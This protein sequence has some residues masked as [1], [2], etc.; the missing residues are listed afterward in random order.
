MEKRDEIY[1][2]IE[3]ISYEIMRPCYGLKMKFNVKLSYPDQKSKERR[4]FHTEYNYTRKFYYNDRDSLCTM[5]INFTPFISLE[6]VK[7]PGSSGMSGEYI[8]LS[9][10][11]LPQ[12]VNSLTKVKEWFYD[13]AFKKLYIMKDGVLILNAELSGTHEYA[14]YLGQ[15][16]SIK[17]LPAI[18]TIDDERYEGIK[19]YL[20]DTDYAFSMTLD[21]FETFFHV[22]MSFNSNL[23]IAGQNAINYLKRPE[24]GR[25]SSLIPD[26]IDEP[27][28]RTS[29]KATSKNLGGRTIGGGKVTE[30]PFEKTRD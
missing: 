10:R 16:K 1:E 17:F 11:Q 28:D 15:G 14:N 27:T 30:S 21:E 24:F 9:Y 13:E 20:N 25:F 2:R 4:F 12:L 8:Y 3:K 5:N 23:F 18:I 22:I 26:S 7:E 6:T 19:F 29:G